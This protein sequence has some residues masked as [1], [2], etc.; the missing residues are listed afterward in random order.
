MSKIVSIRFQYSHLTGF[1]LFVFLF[2]QLY[3]PFPFYILNN[4][5]FL[6]SQ[7][8]FDESTDQNRFVVKPGVD[9][10]LD[11]SKHCFIL[12]LLKIHAYFP[13]GSLLV[14]YRYSVQVYFSCLQISLC[15]AGLSCKTNRDCPLTTDY[16]KI[17]YFTPIFQYLSLL[18]QFSQNEPL[19]P[20][21]LVARTDKIK[22][23]AQ[24]SSFWP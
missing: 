17:R 16:A 15:S 18:L 19:W 8:D 3:P 4:L 9:P 23:R 2:F 20:Q 13:R 21:Y 14:S 1:F 24:S 12:S 7:I 5:N 22:I 10:A 11:E 6:F